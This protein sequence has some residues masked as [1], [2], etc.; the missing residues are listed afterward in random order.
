MWCNARFQCTP[1]SSLAYVATPYRYYGTLRKVFNLGPLQ[2]YKGVTV[3]RW[4]LGALI[5]LQH[6]I[7]STVC[8]ISQKKRTPPQELEYFVLYTL[9][10]FGVPCLSLCHLAQP[11][12]S[13]ICS[14]LW[15]N[16]KFYTSSKSK[17]QETSGLCYN[18]SKVIHR[19]QAVKAHKSSHR[20]SNIEFVNHE[21]LSIPV[22]FHGT[23][24]GK[25][26]NQP[27]RS[28]SRIGCLPL[29]EEL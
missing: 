4:R 19:D 21:T 11:A 28:Q 10:S 23:R 1:G 9:G 18:L 15:Q 6:V 5:L 26:G 13:L 12:Q 27:L 25:V 29:S 14:P 17:V 24:K 16:L 22:G 20:H 7:H 2:R 3:F 8:N